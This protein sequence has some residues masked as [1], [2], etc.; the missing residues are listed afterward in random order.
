MA[1]ARAEAG[2]HPDRR[3]ER[4]D[5]ED[6]SCGRRPLLLQIEDPTSVRVP[7]PLA[8]N[9]DPETA[10]AARPCDP[11]RCVD[12]GERTLLRAVGLRDRGQIAGERDRELVDDLL[13]E[14]GVARPAGEPPL[15]PDDARSGVEEL[16][17][18][19]CADLLDEGGDRRRGW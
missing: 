6:R 5:L 10:E 7:L 12:D 4:G 1:G 16:A 9:R 18:A 3:V 13:G 8:E 14:I 15:A 19:A 11:E 2:D 17:P